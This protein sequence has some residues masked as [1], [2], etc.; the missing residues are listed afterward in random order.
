MTDNVVKLL[1]DG[2]KNHLKNFRGACLESGR[3]EDRV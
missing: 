1:P 2:K 3:S